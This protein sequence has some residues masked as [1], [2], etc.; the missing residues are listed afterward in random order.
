M[1]ETLL[2]INEIPV[3]STFHIL[4]MTIFKDVNETV[5]EQQDVNETVGETIEEFTCRIYNKKTSVSIN[6]ARYKV[7]RKKKE[8]PDLQILPPSQDALKMHITRSNVQTIEWKNALNT[9]KN[10]LNA[11]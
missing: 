2:Y 1:S 7:L 10:A 4:N 8:M 3:E 11:S 9:W 5:N 6:E